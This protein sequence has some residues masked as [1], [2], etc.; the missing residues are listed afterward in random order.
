MDCGELWKTIPGYPCYEVS[1]LGKVR[2]ITSPNHRGF[3]LKG[4]TLKQK[5]DHNGYLGVHL[6]A[7]GKGKRFPVHRIVAKVFIPNPY[8]KPAI[9]HIDCVVTNNRVEN[10]EWC[11]LKENMQHAR[12]LGMCTAHHTK[13]IVQINHSGDIIAEYE[14]IHAASRLNNLTA[15]NI[16]SALRTGRN[17]GG[18]RWKFIKG[19]A[20]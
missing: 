5:P 10:L 20:Q 8:E 12:N 7:C 14:S 6:Y 3:V 18:Y 4:R 9:N 15:G 11:T 1:N 13:P 16:S 17:A 19:E 2:R